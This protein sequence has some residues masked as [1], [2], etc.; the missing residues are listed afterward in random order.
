MR[1]ADVFGGI[2]FKLNAFLLKE[3]DG[4]SN[5]TV[6][7]GV[8]VFMR[9]VFTG[10]KAYLNIV[11]IGAQKSHVF[12]HFVNRPGGVLDINKIRF[13]IGVI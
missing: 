1:R 5:I 7:D 6:V 13:S 10:H 4:R 12:N 11:F 2:F 8:I 9:H 3:L